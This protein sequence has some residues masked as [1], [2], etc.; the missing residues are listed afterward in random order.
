MTAGDKSRTDADI[1]LITL[2]EAKADAPEGSVPVLDLSHL[3][4]FKLVS[5]ILLFISLLVLGRGTMH[6]L[7]VELGLTLH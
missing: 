1:Q 2:P 7:W 4:K 5:N 3:G 6:I